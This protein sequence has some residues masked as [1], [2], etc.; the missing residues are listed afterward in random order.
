MKLNKMNKFL[1]NIKLHTS[2]RFI[3][4]DHIIIL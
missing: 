2:F 4:P 1:L 3:V